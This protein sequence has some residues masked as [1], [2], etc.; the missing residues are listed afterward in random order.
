MVKLQAATVSNQLTKKKRKRQPEPQEE[1]D[2]L[3]SIDDT[4]NTTTVPTKTQD[5]G[6]KPRRTPKGDK[7]PLVRRDS[8]TV[9]ETS[10]PWPSEFTTLAQIHKALNLVYTFCC[11]RKH[12]ATTF[13]NIKST[14]ETNIKQELTIEDVAR[15]KLLL[16]RAINFQYVD[17]EMLQVALMAEE[18]LRGNKSVGDIFQS[19]PAEERNYKQSIGKD[20]HNE[21]LLCTVRNR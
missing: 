16:P 12:F 2:S 17:E 13:E 11:T 20:A 21:V 19:L 10:I 14:V 1:T 8:S 3:A 4:S 9:V 7:P 15:V 6:N 5:G 18:D